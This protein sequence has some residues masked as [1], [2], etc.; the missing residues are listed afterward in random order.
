M[1]LSELPLKLDHF[2]LPDSSSP[3][4]HPCAPPAIH[5]FPRL[6]GSVS[7][8]P[9]NADRFVRVERGVKRFKLS[10]TC[11]LF[12]P[13]ALDWLLSLSKRDWAEV[14]W[15]PSPLLEPS[16]AAQF[17]DLLKFVG[18]R[19]IQDLPELRRFSHQCDVLL[20]AG[21]LGHLLPDLLHFDQS[22]LALL[23]VPGISRGRGSVKS[24]S[25]RPV[26]HESVGGVTDW[27]GTCFA[28]H[29]SLPPLPPSVRRNLGHILE[30]GDRPRVCS[31]QLDFPHLSVDSL[32][33]LGFPL[34]DVAFHSYSS[35][36][37]WGRR[38]LNNAELAGAMD[39]PLWFSLSA[40]FD[41]WLERHSRGLVMP[42]KPFQTMLKCL[43]DSSDPI[44]P[45]D[46]GVSTRS[47]LPPSPSTISS[48]TWL[49]TLGLTLP[50]IWVESGVVT[51]K[52]AKADDAQVHTHLWDK[53]VLLILPE[54]SSSD[55]E[56]LRAFFYVVWCRKL[57][58][59]FQRFM[60]QTHGLSWASRLFS[61]RRLRRLGPAASHPHQ[62]GALYFSF[63][64]PSSTDEELLENG[65]VGSTAL[66]KGLNG[67]WWEWKSGSALFFWRW[68]L[69]Q[70][71]EAR[72]G[73]EIFVRGR[74]PTRVTRGRDTE[75]EKVPAVGAKV[76]KVYKRG[77]VL[78]GEVTNTIDYFDVDKGGDIRVVYDGTKC[79]LNDALFA[80][81]FFLPQA[82]AASRPI[83]PYSWLADSDMGEMFLNFPMD[84][85]IR[86]SSGIDV[87]ALRSEMPG[88]PPLGEGRRSRLLLR[89][90]R[91]FMGM[92]P[93][94]YL[95]VRYYYWA[96]ELARGNPSTP[97]NPMHYSRVI[98]NLPGMPSYDPTLPHV[99]KWN[100]EV[101]LI[102][103]DFITFVDD[104]RVCGHSKENA[105][106]VCR[107]ITSVEQYLG[108]QDAPRKRRPP[109]QKP[110]A[111]AGSVYEIVPAV[112]VTLSVSQAKWEKGQG[113]IFALAET[114][115]KVLPP[116]GLIQ[117]VHKELEKDR[118]FLTHLSMTFPMIVPFLKGFH[119]TLD[120]W[121][122]GRD[123]EGW[124]RTGKEYREWM[125]HFYHSHEGQN[126]QI[127]ELLNAGAP[128]TVT[129][130]PRFYD[131]LDTLVK[132]FKAPSP[133]EITIRSSSIFLVVYGF[134][135]AS[136]KG[137]GS[138]FA[139]G[140]DIS[141]RIGTWG[142]DESGESSNWREFTNVVEALEDE[143]EGGRLFDTVVYFFTDNSTVES[144]MYRGTAG[145]RKLLA[146]VIRLRLL[147]MK[148]SIRLVVSHVAGT[149][150]IAEG[151]DGVSRGLLNEGVM[152]GEDILS[153]IPLH[154]SALDRSPSLLPWLKTWTCLQLE[155]L[156]PADWFGL[157][158][159]IRGW[160]HPQPGDVFSRP[161]LRKGV[162]G[163]FPPPAA[164]DAA[165]EQMRVARI[166]RQDSTH[167]FVVP[168]LLTPNWLK[169]MHKAC[170]IVLT[171]P[172]GTP[173][174]PSDMFEPVLIGIC[175]PFLRFKPW[176][177]KGS[178]KMFQVARD[179]RRLFKNPEMD[180]GP[181]LRKFW[182]DCH[183]MHS[184]QEDVVSRMLY[185]LPLGD[186]PHRAE[187]RTS[188][189]PVEQ[190]RRRGPDEL[191]VAP[192]IKRPR[193]V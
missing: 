76:N 52:A 84:K 172:T 85:K 65:D 116:S 111:W 153:F 39:L 114:C 123:L 147:E 12:G 88:L 28:R 72:D 78:E 161:I 35:R 73:I 22:T 186:F 77:Y 108:I 38:Q 6:D 18:G 24:W 156:A 106:Q 188:D 154:L 74:L 80:P 70:R 112:K 1:E 127:Y 50:G 105:W 155:A 49:P 175:F 191:G 96:E 91:L 144:A 9:F 178:P 170:D 97:T 141:Y 171:I 57:F 14:V 163:W 136:G 71:K 54:F 148:H 33:P 83:M 103:G 173:G 100:D 20:G 133:P 135:D 37:G 158:H 27:H 131:D 53:R 129:P 162:F 5:P 113:I 51:D 75:R 61:L 15:F 67:S 115:L 117:L 149:R 25:R 165:M 29:W 182:K 185:F 79:R 55:L 45:N 42:L 46:S 190:P 86:S 110:G 21:E 157:G 152:A 120:S 142:P 32:L 139:R 66:S 109:S 2:V 151:G 145:S 124:A 164:A 47:V 179:L 192:E 63:A 62:G 125:T 119:L 95:A 159:D 126:D 122:L 56:R 176:Q 23:L 59:C 189:R 137:F 4:L 168:R 44:P 40:H 150:M 26:R 98:L 19:L 177:L 143:A 128:K 64:A 107:R 93:S 134:G 104:T 48:D 16:D 87:T 30:H 8:L 92:K 132:L 31:E 174:W 166:K 138:T 187:G 193:R 82:A 60:S 11:L 36:T 94:P 146:L 160:T 89:W 68:H 41:P 102:A 181:F 43:F 90:E 34:L 13:N 3:L 180:P 58:S 121:R 167:V 184:L 81:G 7:G 17:L 130:V 118:G 101:G 183:R 140:S 10:K 99:M 69:F 169:Q